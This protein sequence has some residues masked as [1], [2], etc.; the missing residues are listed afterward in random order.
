MSTAQEGRRDFVKYSFFK[1][2]PEWRRLSP[3]DRNDSKR[4]FCEVLHP[5]T[6]TG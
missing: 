6:P 4:E 2:A 1:V 5:S 3:E